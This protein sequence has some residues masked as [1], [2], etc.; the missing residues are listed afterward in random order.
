MSLEFKVS[1]IKV[2]AEEIKIQCDNMIKRIEEFSS[3][4]SKDY[5]DVMD[6]EMLHNRME[7]NLDTIKDVI[8]NLEEECDE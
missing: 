1:Q 3:S 4:D 2:N 7:E 5:G 8:D 6:M